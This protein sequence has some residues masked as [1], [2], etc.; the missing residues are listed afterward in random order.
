MLLAVL[1]DESLDQ[2]LEPREV[3]L[4]VPRPARELLLVDPVDRPQ[5]PLERALHAVG[6]VPRVDDR[7]EGLRA[8]L[9]QDLVLLEPEGLETVRA[10][11]HR[12]LDEVQDRREHAAEDV[13]VYLARDMR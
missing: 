8:A 9:Y 11:G 1:L 2:K 7:S 3:G 4:D 12:V 10:R 6:H 13:L 5:Q